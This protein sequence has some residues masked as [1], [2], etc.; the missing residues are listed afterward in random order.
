M[1]LTLHEKQ[2]RAR[3]ALNRLVTNGKAKAGPV[4]ERVLNEAPQDRIT[5][6]NEIEITRTADYIVLDGQPLHKHARGQLFDRLGM[7]RTYATELTSP[8]NFDDASWRRDLLV[9]NLRELASHSDER[10]LVRSF[11]NEVRGVLSDRFRRLDSRPLLDSFIGSVNEVGA[12]P[13][14]GLATEVRTS[15][16]AIVPHVFE[17]IEGEAMV[18]G[19]HWHNSDYGAGTYS[20]N[21][22]A[23][24]LVCL[25]GMLGSTAM[26]QVHLGK[27]LDDRLEYSARTY[28]LDT[29][30][31]ASATR[32]TVRGLLGPKAIE[33]QVEQIRAAHENETTFEEAW[34]KVGKVLGKGEREQVRAHFE[35]GDNVMLPQGQTMWRFS[36]ALSW[37][38]NSVDD[39][40]RK[41][42]LQSAAAQLVAA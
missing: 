32:D 27:R 4:I 40:D 28:E 9:H 19:L 5:R 16:R 35:G 1:D 2:D 24:R 33:S 14:E 26:R 37:L 29:E 25:N 30:A 15:V 12:V 22:F 42:E 7:P 23:L 41:L 6:G 13:Y 36:N 38:A 31:T 17:P 11:G 20:V 18:F 3:D 39:V 21:A 8:K 10:M 34:R